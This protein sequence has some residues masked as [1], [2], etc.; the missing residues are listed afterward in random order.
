MKYW[1]LVWTGKV[2]TTPLLLAV[3]YWRDETA[4]EV[5]NETPIKVLDC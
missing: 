2:S 4:L 5:V 3:E 1:I